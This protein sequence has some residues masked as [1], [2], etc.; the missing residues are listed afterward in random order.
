MAITPY[1]GDPL[2]YALGGEHRFYGDMSGLPTGQGL[3]G[4]PLPEGGGGSSGL[5]TLAGI[6]AV[7][8]KLPIGELKKIIKD[9]PKKPDGTVS[10]PEVP[11]YDWGTALDQIRVDPETFEVLVDDGL[12]S[13][14]PVDQSLLPDN[15]SGGYLRGLDEALGDLGAD[16]TSLPDFDLSGFD[17]LGSDLLPDVDPGLSDLSALDPT[18][19]GT[20]G[21]FG[22]LN[23]MLGG[24]AP[25]LSAAGAGMQLFNNPNALT[26]MN[27][28]MQGLNALG[29][30]GALGAGA[31]GWAAAAA[32]P[33]AVMMAIMQLGGAFDPETPRV[34]VASDFSFGPDGKLSAPNWIDT[35]NYGAK[36]PD[37]YYEMVNKAYETISGQLANGQVDPSW[38]KPGTRFSIGFGSDGDIG[39]DKPLLDLRFGTGNF[40][41]GGDHENP[42]G[43][44]EIGINWTGS[45]EEVFGKLSSQLPLLS[46]APTFET[47]PLGQEMAKLQ[48]EAANQGGVPDWWAYRMANN[49]LGGWNGGGA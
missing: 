5:S 41:P 18:Q 24:A 45:P 3:P 27:F 43:G 39:L 21:G 22:G 9:L 34:G 35:S 47:T 20:E 2:R 38:L 37:P 4:D 12:G 23:D 13:L 11:G 26:G 44:N 48:S 46:A 1:A 40:E 10:L 29:S 42:W 19:F 49:N 36:A 25:W 30:A 6:A 8:S 17:T 32:P 33:L 14:T 31:A 28:G 7:I 16:V 15:L